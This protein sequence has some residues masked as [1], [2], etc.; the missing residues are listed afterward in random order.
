[1]S[2]FLRNRP[3][4]ILGNPRSGTSLLRLMLHCHPKI[5]I[6]PESHF[7]LWLEEK[8]GHWNKDLIEGYLEDL[9]KSTKFE[10]WKIDRNDLK[11]YLKKF[12]PTSYAELTSLVYSYYAKSENKMPI[13][14][15]DKNSLWIDKLDKIKYY[16][17]DAFVVHLIRDGRDVACSYREINKKKINTPYAPKLSNNIAEIAENWNL[18]NISVEEFLKSLPRE[19]YV[20][21]KYEELLIYPNSI[22]KNI[23]R[24]LDLEP[25]SEQLEYYLKDKKNIEPEEFFRWK[26]KLNQPLDTKNIE[27]YIDILTDGEVDIFNRIAKQS[28]SKY[29]YL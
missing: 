11:F 17:P 8:Y 14:W 2:K 4:F 16:Y 18:S 9:Y 12:S 10:T 23:L 26:E 21:V 20:Q 7:F 27:K 28:L 5:C 6:P 3:I 19:Q 25:T 1:M 22:L 29:N 13:Y 15:G 24:P